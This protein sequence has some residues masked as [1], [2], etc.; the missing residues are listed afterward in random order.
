MA[1]PWPVARKEDE[2]ETWPALPMPLMIEDAPKDAEE[3]EDEPALLKLI[4]ETAPSQQKRPPDFP[5]PCLPEY[6]CTTKSPSP[7]TEPKPEPSAMSQRALRR[8][9][10]APTS[11][12][13]YSGRPLPWSRDSEA[14]PITPGSRGV[15][16]GTKAEI[17]FSRASERSRSIGKQPSLRIH[18]SQ[19][20]STAAGVVD[21][22]GSRLGSAK[23]N[24]KLQK[25]GKSCGL[26]EKRRN[27]LTELRQLQAEAVGSASVPLGANLAASSETPDLYSTLMPDASPRA[28]ENRRESTVIPKADAPAQA[29][30]EKASKDDKQA[31]QQDREKAWTSA[32]KRCQT[33][34]EIHRDRLMD[35]IH[36]IGF[37][38]PSQA[39]IDAVMRGSD[40]QYS[41]LSAA[42]FLDFVRGYEDK[43]R[44]AFAQEFAKFDEDNSGQVDVKELTQLLH[45]LGITPLPVV[46]EATI[47]EVDEDATGQLDVSEFERVLGLLSMREGFTKPEVEELQR[48]FTKFDR[49][50]DGEVGSN[51]LNGILSWL[52]YPA[53]P[54]VTD[55]IAREVDADGTGELSW[56]EFLACMRKFR[57]RETA[58]VRALMIQF[59]DDGSGTVDWGKGELVN[60]LAELGYSA[61]H[62]AIAEAAEEAKITTRA[63]GFE[64]LW[65]LLKFYRSRAGFTRA[66]ESVLMD[67]FVRYEIKSE[68]S[69]RSSEP[70]QISTLDVGKALR[71]LGY[72]E[73]IE[74]Q[75]FL[76]AA[77][78][79]DHSGQLDF[80]EFRTLMAIRRESE[81][82][83]IRKAYH[84]YAG[85][86]TMLTLESGQL[87][88]ALVTV[89]CKENDF[90][91]SEK[92][93]NWFGFLKI[94]DR[95]RNLV[96]DRMRK[97]AGFN[98]SEVREYRQRFSTYDSDGSGEI[99]GS[100]LRQ[101]LG[102]ILPA[103]AY[104]L[105]HRARLEKLLKEAD[106]DGNGKLDLSDFL[107]LMRHHHDD[108][109]REELEKIDSA[110]K[111]TGFSDEEAQQ[112]R[113][114][115]EEIDVESM[116]HIDLNAIQNMLHA[117][118]PLYR[119]HIAQL[120]N[121]FNE[122]ACGG[123]EVDFPEFLRVLKKV[124]ECDL[125]GIKTATAKTP[126]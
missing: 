51:E 57:E 91:P 72:G 26:V 9:N 76:V 7:T 80:A 88:R 21:V 86:A 120:S 40:I 41:T 32:F 98:D 47:A 66:E 89:G 11:K 77:V 68:G 28:N 87:Q 97:H 17:I 85:P 44:E 58:R 113:T 94:V 4:Q 54:E 55:A 119:N 23:R 99:S 52:G 69:A 82:K 105:K 96:R 13:S 64:E 114:I 71:M 10:T 74:T 19:S 34:G 109:D 107:R 8:P 18:S 45:N 1:L 65:S 50:G 16:A 14:R 102:D 20:S 62:E 118:C 22:S 25:G 73:R 43:Q 59:D 123:P 112:F 104:S 103:A 33:D 2:V 3:E 29:E 6:R 116:G 126:A 46:L 124:L 61:N 5:K 60:L 92:E 95:S 37:P 63:L 53:Q 110:I 12:R 122:V 48:V 100:E 106:Q 121:I 38:R 79:V 75:R 15:Y 70:G 67:T 78:D 31:A 81:I 39:W 111:D 93:V 42:E 101:L 83:E 30:K 84:A 108:C 24:A 90:L 27:E 115:F 49:S 56:A 36:I 125:A 117:V 35:A